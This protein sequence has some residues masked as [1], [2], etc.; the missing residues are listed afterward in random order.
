M[1]TFGELVEALGGEI[2]IKV[3][4]L[5]DPLPVLSNYHAYA[6]YELPTI[7]FTPP[8][9]DADLQSTSTGTANAKITLK[10]PSL[11]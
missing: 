5:E 1:R 4:A 11:P 2:E 6:E 9:K 7:S 10:A 8:P 3:Y